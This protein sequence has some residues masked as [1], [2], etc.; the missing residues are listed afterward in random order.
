VTQECPFDVLIPIDGNYTAHGLSMQTDC[1]ILSLDELTFSG[2]SHIMHL[3]GSSPDCFQDDFL[4]VADPALVIHSQ[5]NKAN[6]TRLP[7][8]KFMELQQTKDGDDMTV[9]FGKNDDVVAILHLVKVSLFGNSFNAT[10]KIENNVLQISG[11]TA[12]FQYPAYVQIS[13]LA[14]ETFWN[15][16]T[17]TVH[18]DMLPGNDSF[19]ESVNSEV[20]SQMRQEADSGNS[21]KNVAQMSYG[22]AMERLNNASYEYNQSLEQMYEANDSYNFALLKIEIAR[23]QLLEVQSVFHSSRADL[24]ELERGLNRICTDE[25]CENI[26]MRGNVCRNCFEH[27]FVEKTGHCPTTSKETKVIRV[28]PYFEQRTTWEWQTVCRTESNQE[29][30]EAECP[31]GQTKTCNAKCVPVTSTIPVYHWTTVE[32][33]VLRYKSCTVQIINSSIPSTCCEINDC[34]VFAPNSTCVSANALCRQSRETALAKARENVRKPFEDLQ[35]ARRNLS[36]AQTAA[37]TAQIK[38]QMSQRRTN[39][40]FST[41]ERRRAASAVA[42][43]VYKQTLQ[44]IELLIKIGDVIREHSIKEVFRVNNI[45]FNS[46]FIVQSPNDLGV[47]ILYETPYNLSF[48]HL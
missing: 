4:G 7:L 3:T 39:E 28:P 48:I 27:T 8:G 10:A 26:C 24:L 22:L 32:V 34:A 30:F 44:Q 25:T 36:L 2:M 35:A 43:R 17:F 41:L 23:S 20:V 40:S 6:I 21:R 31:V 16:L 12:V 14:N 11:N 29:C 19:L 15:N 37:T 1:P 33:D 42:E 9:V 5:F 13:A 45:T 47:N 38:F 18:G 46:E